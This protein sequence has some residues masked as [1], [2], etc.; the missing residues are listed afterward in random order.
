MKR[1]RFL[2][3]TAMLC[4][5][6]GLQANPTAAEETDICLT[7]QEAFVQWEMISDVAQY[8]EADWDNFAFVVCGVNPIQAKQI[9]EM[10]PEVTYF[11][12]VKGSQLVLE[13]GDEARV[14]QHG[15]AV[16]F[17]GEPW[18]GSAPDLADGYI[19][20]PVE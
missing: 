11:F 14:F 1:T 4:S 3:L 17:T 9:A 13:Y 16:F 12:F 6:C 7:E 19:K 18:W 20:I 10:N 2:L 5:A 15:D 8:K